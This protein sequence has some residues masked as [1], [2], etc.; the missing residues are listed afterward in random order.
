MAISFLSFGFSGSRVSGSAPSAL[1]SVVVSAVA[2][3]GVVSCGCARGV[4]AVVR[5]FASSIFRVSSFG[6]GRGAFARR[7]IA[8]VSAL[9]SSPDPV[10]FCFPLGLCP[11]PLVPSASPSA[12]FA[13]F[14][15]GSWASAAFAVGLG[16]PVVVFGV[17]YSDL[18]ASWRSLFL[19]WRPVVVGGVAGF[20]LGG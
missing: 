5:P 6:V 10:L 11:A 14:G 13:G 20:V 19:F 7:S 2:P 18:P 12:C 1:A 17:D 15:S 16:V 9:A 3:C 8:F 4:D